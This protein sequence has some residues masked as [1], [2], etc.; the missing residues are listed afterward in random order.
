MLLQ[1]IIEKFEFFPIKCRVQRT[2]EMFKMREAAR[3]EASPTQKFSL[4]VVHC[5]HHPAEAKLVLLKCV[6]RPPSSPQT[7]LLKCMHHWVAL[8]H[9]LVV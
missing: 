7:R 2:L 8:L 6:Q 1:A 3:R 9:C 5:N 4:Q